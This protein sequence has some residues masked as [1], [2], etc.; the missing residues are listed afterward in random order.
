MILGR[1]RAAAGALWREAIVLRAWRHHASFPGIAIS[2]HARLDIRGSFEYGSGCAIADHA[3]VLVSPGASLRFGD[4]VRLGRNTEL[5]ATG[6]IRIGDGTTLQDRTLLV[7]SVTVG[8]YCLFSLNVLATSGRHYFDVEPEVYIRDQ[9]AA[10]LACP[11]L[12]KQHDRPVVIEDDCWIGANAF[13]M[14][15][16]HVG[17]GCVIGTGAVVTADLPPYSVAVGSP[18]RVVRQR[19]D[20]RPPPGIRS[21]RRADAP[22]FYSGIGLSSRERLIG[23]ADQGLLASRQFS[24]ALDVAQGGAFVIEASSPGGRKAIRHGGQD[25][26]LGPAFSHVEF[27][28]EPDDRGLLRFD[29]EGDDTRWPV[30]LRAAWRK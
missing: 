29:I 23:Q 14:S 15:G 3:V 24:L 2:P 13:V 20:F 12:A 28:A 25:A 5:G 30:R 16:V 17:K 11:K 19:L 7:G 26:S 18:A 6:A 8:R 10:V 27:R 4:G 21:D 9:D 22:Y 1:I